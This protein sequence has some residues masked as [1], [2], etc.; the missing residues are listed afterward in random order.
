L[1]DESGGHRH[2]CECHSNGSLNTHTDTQAQTQ[3]QAH[4]KEIFSGPSV[5]VVAVNKH[6]V[7][8]GIFHCYCSGDDAHPAGTWANGNNER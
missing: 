2:G 5:V 8:V 7:E 6:V 4:K 3:T 1:S